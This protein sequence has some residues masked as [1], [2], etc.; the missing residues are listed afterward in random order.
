MARG[1]V[2]Q[3]HSLMGKAMPASI[4]SVEKNGTIVKVKLEL[5]SGFTLPEIT[6]PVN[7]PEW[8]RY[9]IQVGDKGMVIP[10][11]YALGAMNGMGSGVA[12]LGRQANLATM[13]WHPIGNKKFEDR[14][15]GEDKQVVIYGPD[16]VVVKTS[17]G[18]KGKIVVD[19][20]GVRN[21][22]KGKGNS[23]VDDQ[24]VSLFNKSDDKGGDKTGNYITVADD[25]FK[26]Y[27]GGQLKLIVDGGG[28]RMIG[29][30]RP[31]GGNYGVTVTPTGTQ[32]DNFNWLQHIHQG[33]QPGSGNSQK[34]NDMVS[35]P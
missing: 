22:Q 16:G 31:G 35:P 17:K 8:V 32:I 3:F 2:D 20:K 25:G 4:V 30:P 27:I 7:G 6:V 28:L 1:T 24:G 29:G 5:K 18:D 9:P 12:T 21:T 34:I 19:D 23:T 11:D 15:D 14:D 33:V 10:S 26:V 13:V